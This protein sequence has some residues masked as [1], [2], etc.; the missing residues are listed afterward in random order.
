MKEGESRVLARSIPTITDRRAQ[1]LHWPTKR[2]EVEV[3]DW[4]DIPDNDPDP[5]RLH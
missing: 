1:Q 2:F 5:E 4:V 3:P